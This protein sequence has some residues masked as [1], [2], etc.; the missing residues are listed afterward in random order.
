V[1]F[2]STFILPLVGL[3][4][5]GWFEHFLERKCTPIGDIQ[6]DGMPQDLTPAQVATT[7]SFTFETGIRDRSGRRR[8][9][10]FRQ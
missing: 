3:C 2:A 6:E 1:L 4:A 8:K 9:T 5:T 10:K 7:D